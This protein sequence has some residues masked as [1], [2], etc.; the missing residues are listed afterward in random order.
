MAMN[1][2]RVKNFI[3]EEWS[4]YADYDN[5]RSI[6]HLMDGLKITQRKAMYT[7]TTLPKN[8]KPLRVSQFASKNT[9]K[10]VYHH[11]EGAGPFDGRAD[12]PRP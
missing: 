7:A 1:D 6:P 2:I 9:K 12:H 3:S 5:R 10:T 8:D 11:G 4:E